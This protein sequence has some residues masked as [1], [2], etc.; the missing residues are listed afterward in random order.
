MLVTRKP[1]RKG[2]KKYK[3]LWSEDTLRDQ[4]WWLF[5]PQNKVKQEV[6]VEPG[7]DSNSGRSSGTSL[8]SSSSNSSSG[9]ASSGAA[10]RQQPEVMVKLEPGTADEVGG[11]Q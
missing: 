4:L 7:V 10:P 3:I 8:G 9:L 1:R 6:K 5:K 2:K 11:R